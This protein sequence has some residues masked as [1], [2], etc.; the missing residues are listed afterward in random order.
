M[1]RA[2]RVHRVLVTGSRNWTDPTVIEEKLDF[3]ARRAWQSGLSMVVVHGDC[4]NGADK[5]A[6]DWAKARKATGWPIEVEAY[7]AAWSTLGPKAG[8][9][10]NR[11]MVSKGAAV[12]L[13]FILDQSSG[14]TGCVKEARTAELL[15]D[16]TSTESGALTAS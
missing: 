14:A 7:P 3:E 6:D 16:V 10:R 8:P 1:P 9:I 13:A 15:L 5:I 12:V 4:P 11:Y 2:R